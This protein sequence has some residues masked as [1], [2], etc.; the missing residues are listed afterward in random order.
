MSEADPE[1][2]VR[3]EGRAGRLTLNRPKALNA[4]TLGMVRTLWATL[5]AWRSD[6]AVHVV[7]LDGSGDRALC[8]GGDVRSLYDS[9]GE[10][11]GLARTFWREEYRLNA[12]IHRYPK[13]VVGLMDG[14]VMGG[15]IGL[16]AHIQ[17]GGRI[18]TDRSMLAMPETGIGL[19][20][21]VGGTWL[22]G[23]AIGETGVYLG[24]IGARMNGADAIETGFADAYLEHGRIG[25]LMQ[26]LCDSGG[27]PLADIMDEIADEPVPASPLMEFKREID[28]CFG[29]PTVEAIL[30]ELQT[31]TAEWAQKAHAEL[32][33][34]SPLALKAA[35][36]AIHRARKLPAL[37]EA[38]N[39]EFRLCTHLFECGEFPEGVRALLVDKDKTPKWKPARL[40]DVTQAMVE[41]L[42]A[43]FPTADEP[44]LS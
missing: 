17:G 19:I 44:G 14:I 40:E 7:V 6:P 24:L 33:Q 28:R 8:A 35:L 29:K 30:A 9:R 3:I 26:K 27:P 4:L 32:K 11:S 18:V 22:L 34:K 38:L 2:L 23:R 20:P 1:V 10:G 31:T 43:P 13:P 12:L 42:F 41:A 36:T 15:G 5:N 21:D 16:S 39:A 37:E 25:S